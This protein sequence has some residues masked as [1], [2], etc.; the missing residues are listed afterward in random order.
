MTCPEYSKVLSIDAPLSFEGNNISEYCKTFLNGLLNKNYHNRFSMDQAIN[1]PWLT[2]T[3]L[4][5][6]EIFERY[7]SDPEKMINVLN[8]TQITEEYFKS[9]EQDYKL[10]NVSEE[11]K[12]S[13]DFLSKKRRRNKTT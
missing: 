4:K 11:I 3:K 9:K 6:D 10:I 1:H 5:V 8:N 2:F 12:K 7:Q 13:D